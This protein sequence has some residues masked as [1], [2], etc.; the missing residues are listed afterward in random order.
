MTRLFTFWRS[1]ATWRVRIAPALK[2]I[3]A[4]LVSVDLIAGRQFEDDFAGQNPESA[5]PLLTID[6]ETLAQ[7]MAIMEYLEETRPE[8]PLLP[9]DPAERALARRLAQIAVADSHPLIVPRVRAYLAR[10]AGL[11]EEAIGRWAAHW[12]MRGCGAMETILSAR[13]LTGEGF[14][15]SGR[16]GIVEACL[17]PQLGGARNF[18]G[19]PSAFPT[20]MRIEAACAALEPFE[21]AHQKNQPDVPRG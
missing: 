17:I 9:A 4:E 2:G 8:P 14:A 15:F 20:L 19:D 12:L 1:L 10:E 6:G 11:G 3:E 21:K 7:S 18:G 13:G 5:V 16:P